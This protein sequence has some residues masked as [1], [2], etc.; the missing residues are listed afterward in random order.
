[1]KL[2]IITPHGGDE[3]SLQATISSVRCLRTEEVF[4]EHIIVVNNGSSLA[5]VQENLLSSI[6]LTYL[7][8]NPI[9]CRAKSRNAAL[10]YLSEKNFD[11]Y[12]N[13]L[14]SGDLIESTILDAISE[15]PGSQLLW[16]NAKIKTE[17]EVRQKPRVSPKLKKL[18]NPFYLGAVLVKFETVQGCRFQNGRKE[19][20]KFWLDLFGESEPTKVNNVFY[21]YTIKSRADHF[22]RKI[23][24]FK[25]QWLFF[26]IYLNHNLLIASL[27]ILLHYSINVVVW[28]LF[29]LKK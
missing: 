4:I 24:L 8:I 3:E 6:K 2:A 16:G 21:T 1:M 27:K 28:S 23:A 18:V 22:K 19:D 26:R 9:A 5:S 17:T 13:F 12:I 7:D 11:G 14:D 10:D 29:T 20:W 15:N 25:D